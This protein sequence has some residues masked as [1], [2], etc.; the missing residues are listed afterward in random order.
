[1]CGRCRILAVQFISRS[2]VPV[3]CQ[4]TDTEAKAKLWVHYGSLTY[5]LN[6]SFLVYTEPSKRSPERH[7]TNLLVIQKLG[8]RS[9][10]NQIKCK[11]DDLL[12]V[13]WE[14]VGILWVGFP[15]VNT[16]EL[17]SGHV[18]CHWVRRS[19]PVCIF[20]T[21][22]IV[23]NE[24]AELLFPSIRLSFAWCIYIGS[25]SLSHL[26]SILVLPPYYLKEHWILKLN[27]I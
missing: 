26:C 8:L 6:I 21:D 25:L 17:G 27:N 12:M 22:K 7:Q 23:M 16:G 4:G 19:F 3:C 1:M 24:W 11:V 9:A 18:W 5:C 10:I 13:H 14:R 2:W 15:I 20:I